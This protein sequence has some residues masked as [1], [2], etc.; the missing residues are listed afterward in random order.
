MIYLDDTT[1]KLQLTSSSAEALAVSVSFEDISSAGTRLNGGSQETAI[2]SA[3]TTDILAAPAVSLQRRV[4]A[5]RVTNAGVGSN[6]VTVIKDVNG[7]DYA[8]TAAVALGASEML[9][10]DGEGGLAV[11]SSAGALKT[12][13][14]SGG[15]GDALTTDP[16]SQFAATTSAQLRGVISDETG[17]G[18]LVFATSPTLVTP[19]LGTPA[20]GT[21]TNCTGLPISTGVSGLAANV[22]TALATPS[23]ANLAAAVTDETGS[24]A[25]VFATSPTLVTPVL[26]TPASG[27]L[28]NCT[29]LP[30]STGVSGLAAN[31]ATALATPSSANL[32]AAITDETGSGALVFATSPTLVTPALGTPASGTLTNCTGLPISTGVSGLAANVATALATPSS[33][34]LAAAVTDETG[35]GALVFAT[36]PT[37]VTPALGTPASGTLTSCTGLPMTTGL[38]GG[39]WKTTY[40][41][42]SGAVTE[43]SLPAVGKFLMGNG[44]AAAPTWETGFRRILKTADET[45]NSTTTLAND[46][47]LVV[48]LG[49]STSYV[50]RL[51][52]FTTIANATM[53]FKFATAYSGT[54]TGN[55][56]TAWRAA[57][58]GV[59][60]G[61]SAEFQ[62]ISSGQIASTAL[63]AA[64]SG[65]GYVYVDQS[66]LTDA[67]GTWSFQWAQ[68]T[69]DASNATVGRGSFIEYM[70]VA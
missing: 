41:D 65:V 27:T 14:G 13:G 29:G 54:V 22:A 44:A 4:T 59:A 25:L 60:T 21:L 39:N 70:V 32:A 15:G 50:I 47:A 36:S 7:T 69:S 40:T 6:S 9:E 45:R 28:T 52:V 24:G 48:S 1:T 3:T 62:G 64:T 42:G 38:V 43:L 63:T 10:I 34:N 66:I 31:V 26:G 8:L 2:S 51:V 57:A 5:L 61:T 19:A 20:S 16:L 35:S 17:T 23:S 37:L 68:N 49:A 58:G 53:D 55:V 12:S 33:A 46:S 11:F 56:Y 30:I 18:V 67:A